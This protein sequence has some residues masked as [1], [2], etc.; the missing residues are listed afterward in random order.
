MIKKLP[1]NERPREKLIH[2]GPGSLSTA[3]LLAIIYQTG[4]K[5]KSA[6][7]LSREQLEQHKSL[8]QLLN[9]DNK[10]FCQLTGM[11]YTKYCLLQAALELARRYFQ[12]NLA[13]G[14]SFQNSQ[15]AHDYLRAEFCAIEQEVFGV[16][17]L[18]TKHR[19]IEFKKLFYGTIHRVEIHPREILKTALK[20]NA[21]ALILAHNHPSGDVEPSPVDKSMT[22]R[23]KQIL[24]W[25]EVNLLDHI[26]LGNGIYFSFVEQGML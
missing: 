23:L 22:S 10:I 18:D 1:L 6:L 15:A 5:G 20:Y 9:L 21:S 12:E 24:S 19:I 26:I 16:L 25:V 17:Y 2:H 7:D 3:E 13:Q 11:G 14:L 8:R 4:I